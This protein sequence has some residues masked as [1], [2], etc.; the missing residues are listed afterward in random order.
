MVNRILYARIAVGFIT[1]IAALVP[2]T[3]AGPRATSALSINENDIGGVVA[4]F[5]GPE[6][7]VWVVA[8]TTDLPTKYAKIV[9]TDDQGRYL[10]PELPPASYQV[11]VR[12]YGLIDSPRVAAKPG[13]HL[14]LSGCVGARWAGGRTGLSG[15]AIG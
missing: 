12:G 7:G 9:V 3:S 4:S 8:E 15:G 1:I 13:Q 6:A 14:D 2:K 11:F 10:M 5:K